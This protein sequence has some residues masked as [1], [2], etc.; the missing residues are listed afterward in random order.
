ME[1]IYPVIVKQ[2]K[3]REGSGGKGRYKGGEG[4][5]R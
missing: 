5:I 1:S 2:F 4:V 3:K